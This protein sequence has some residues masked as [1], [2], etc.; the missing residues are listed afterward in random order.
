MVQPP[1]GRSSQPFHCND[2]FLPSA[3]LA[4]VNEARTHMGPIL[5]HRPLRNTV[6]RGAGPTIQQTVGR[7]LHR[8]LE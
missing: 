1:A 2:G 8:R 5:G 3:R 6:A 4:F 7:R